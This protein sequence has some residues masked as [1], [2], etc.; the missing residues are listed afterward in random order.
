MKAPKAPSL[1]AAASRGAWPMIGAFVR[2]YPGRS[3]AALGAVFVAGLLDGLGLSMLLSMLT[4]ATDGDT[5]DPSCRSRWR[6]VLPQLS[7]CNRPRRYC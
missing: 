4:L 2:A 3:A 6:C 1:A 7:A 5:A